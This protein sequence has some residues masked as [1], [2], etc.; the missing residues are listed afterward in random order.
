MILFSFLRI[1]ALLC[2]FLIMFF[3]G[4]LNAQTSVFRLKTGMSSIKIT[5]GDLLNETELKSMFNLTPSVLWDFP[6]F[7]SRFGFQYLMELNSQY[8]LTPMSGIGIVAYYHIFGITSGFEFTKDD[9]LIQKSKP[10]PY[11]VAAVTPVN[12]N[13]NKF[14]PE[15]S[16]EENLY[17]SAYVTDI[18]L[19]LG[20][21]YPILDNMT[22]SGEFVLRNGR[23][24]ESTKENI[25][26][27]GWTIYFSI[28]STYF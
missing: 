25:S 13:L 12:V 23:S 19:G 4:K 28:A 6:S 15:Q 18:T 20:Y 16:S 24:V 2:L 7:S 1:Q 10:G 17:L 14:D 8:G 3:H 22:M 9:V 5:S 21:D 27:S 11:I 26:Y